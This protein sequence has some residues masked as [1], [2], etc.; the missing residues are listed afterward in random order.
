MLSIYKASA[1]SGKT[2]A[3]TRE[4]IRMLLT[5]RIHSDARLPHSRILAVTFTKKSTAEMKERILKELFILAKTPDQSD[6]IEEFTS[7]PSI[8]LSKDA[9]QQRAQLLL[10]GILQDYNR[11]SVS[12][13]DGF[14]QQVIRT[15]ALELGLSTTYDLALDHKEIVNQA[16]DDIFRRIRAIKPEDEDLA[17][18]LIEY[19]QSNIDQ[20]KRWNPIDNIKTFSSELSKEQLIQQ[21]DDLQKTFADKVLMRKYLEQLSSIRQ[22]TLDSI[23]ALKNTISNTI[24]RLGENNINT[25]IVNFFLKRTP[26]II[27]KDGF[28]TTLLKAMNGEGAF[29]KKTGKSKREQ[30]LLQSTCDNELLPQ[31]NEL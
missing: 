29:Y 18:W 7:D 12:T 17:T 30:E 22:Q 10:V 26:E 19:A 9:I 13:I 23:D 11:F 5:D 20:N 1:G 16:V 21:M 28:N 14:F 15:F 27:I 4:Y 8:G 24:S 31:V 6:Y 3:L 25:H 2:F